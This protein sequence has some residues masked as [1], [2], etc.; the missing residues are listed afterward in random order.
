MIWVQ[1][2]NNNNSNNPLETIIASRNYFYQIKSF[3]C[4]YS[5]VGDHSR[6]WPEGYLFNSYNTKV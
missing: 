2:T 4:T 5:K 1:A 3:V 6:E